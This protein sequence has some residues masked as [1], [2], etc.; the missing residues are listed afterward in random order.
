M[1]KGFVLSA[2]EI[3]P[4]DKIMMLARG[5][6]ANIFFHKFIIRAI[7]REDNRVIGRIIGPVQNGQCVEFRFAPDG[8]MGVKIESGLEALSKNE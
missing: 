3:N 7:S 4:M 1:K 2:E 8:W 6:F 5:E